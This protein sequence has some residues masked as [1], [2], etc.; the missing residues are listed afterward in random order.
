MLQR[1]K[2]AK[3]Q[4]NGALPPAVPSAVT[5][6]SKPA[7]ISPAVSPIAQSNSLPFSDEMYDNFK[8]VIAKLSGRMKSDA[9]LSTEDF[10]KYKAAV[11][12][13]I[14]DAKSGY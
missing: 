8:F 1:A 10:A 4:K 13:I 7:A 2:L 9:P 5:S 3:A 6:V 12:A 14:A 11:E